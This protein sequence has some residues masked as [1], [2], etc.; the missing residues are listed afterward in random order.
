MKSLALTAA[1]SALLLFSGCSTVNPGDPQAS[2]PTEASAIPVKDVG[3]KIDGK[4]NAKS[5]NKADGKTSLGS[6]EMA[7][8][9]VRKLQE[10]ASGAKSSADK[11]GNQ[12]LAQD[13][14]KGAPDTANAEQLNDPSKDP[15]N[16]AKSVLA[17]RSIYFDYDSFEVKK[18]FRN[19]VEA[20][21]K[22][23]QTNPKKK[24]LI[25]G[26]TDERG[27]AE[28]N[29]ALGQKR[30]E[31]V[32]KILSLSGAKEE[33]LE[34]VSLGKEKPKALSSDE[35]SWAENRRVDLVY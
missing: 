2:A 15:L 30:A 35:A 22:Y 11:G 1:L 34:A 23:L 18:E 14:G 12:D 31:S 24:I 4:S 29:L 19:I 28:Y 32:K 25:Q 8:A 27:G 3:G 6:V 21:G 7:D 17:K 9:E 26:H 16:D 10:P 20:H 13:S 33:Q 5:D